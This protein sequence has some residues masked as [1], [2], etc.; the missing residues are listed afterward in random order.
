MGSVKLRRLILG[1][2]VAGTVIN[3]IELLVHRLILKQAW[4]AAFAALGRT[5]T[6]W[7]TFIPSNFLVGIAG[8]WLYVAIRPRYGAGP[9]T[10]TLAGLGVWLVFWVIPTMALMPLALF[11]NRL[12]VTVIGVWLMD[13]VLAI[14]FGA[15]L[16]KEV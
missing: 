16:Y 7:M 8:V 6:G 2:L 5:P 12:L 3:A 13:A 1:G 10:A 4:T 14:L 15:W 9:K 11:P